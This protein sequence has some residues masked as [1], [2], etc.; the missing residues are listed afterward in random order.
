M[1][2]LAR[3]SIGK[4]KNTMTLLRRNNQVIHVIKIVN[5]FKFFRSNC[6]VFSHTCVAQF[7]KEI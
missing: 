7:C 1:R 5:L 2:K 4:Q 3:R 6:D